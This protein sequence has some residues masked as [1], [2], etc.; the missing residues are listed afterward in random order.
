ML[1]AK[2]IHIFTTNYDVSLDNLLLENPK[3]PTKYTDGFVPYYSGLKFEDHFDNQRRY[4]V[5]KLHGSVNWKQDS[6][7]SNYVE[8]THL[9]SFTS[10]SECCMLFPG[11]KSS[12]EYPFYLLYKL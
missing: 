3:E 11:S 6:Q 5:Y 10:L 4:K 7:N 1:K 2:T 8:R 9:P 12:E